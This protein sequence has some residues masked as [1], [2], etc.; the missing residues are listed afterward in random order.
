MRTV[1]F[2]SEGFRG[3][4]VSLTFPAS[5]DCPDLFACG[6]FHLSKP[7]MLYLS[8]H[9]FEIISPYASSQEC[10][11]ILNPFDYIELKRTVF[12][13]TVLN[14]ITLVKPLLPDKV[15]IFTG[16]SNQDMLFFFFFGNHYFAYYTVLIG[17]SNF[18]E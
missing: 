2:L 15:N 12:H 9:S 10:F 6:L 13:L 1:V 17:G 14:V 3:E 16:S 4:S 8:D 7:E 18:F 5:R 11:P